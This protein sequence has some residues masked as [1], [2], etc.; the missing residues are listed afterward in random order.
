MSRTLASTG[1]LVLCVV[2]LARAQNQAAGDRCL[3]VSA[4]NIV[5]G[6]GNWYAYIEIADKPYTI[7]P[8]DRLEYDIYLPA[9]NPL[10]KG[11]V[12]ADLKRD[13]LGEPL[14]SR[15]WVRDCGIK[16]QN[17]ILLHG[18]GL[19]ELAK[20][21]W[22]QRSFDLSPLAGCTTARWT[23]VFEGDLPGRYVQLLDNIRVT[24]A[25]RTALSLYEDGKAPEIKLRQTDGYSRTVLL[26]TAPRA[27][28][29]SDAA[30]AKLLEDAKRQN[31]A[32]T[33]RDQF[34]AEIDV[35][36]DLARQL[37]DGALAAEVDE[38]AKSAAAESEKALAEGRYEELL[39][40]LHRA[41]HR[42]GHAHPQM[43]KF[44]G[45]LVGHAHIDLQWLWTWDE[46]LNQIIPQ[47]FGQAVK[48]MKEFRD[49]TFSQSSACLYLAA[50]QHHPQL[51]KEMQ[52]MVARGQWEIVGGRWCEGDT[53]MIS[54]ESHVRH[55]LYGQR[56]FQSRFGRMATVG[57]EPDTFGHCWTLPQVLR[58][59]GIDSY[60]FCRAG[61][62][63]PL[64][65]W[66]GP[67]GSRVLAFEEPATGGW[68]N[69]VVSDEKVRE[70]AKFI[71]T[72]G[73]L[74]HLMVYGVGNH[75]GGPTREYIQ[76]ALAMRQRGLWPNIRFS[77]ASEFFKRLHEQVA[78]GAVQPPAIRDELNPVFEGCYT[79]H[80]I[81]KK[82]NRDA[83]TLLETAE[84]WAALAALSDT[85][86]VTSDKGAGGQ[87]GSA[88][89]SVTLHVSPVT[90]G[91]TGS[92]SG[93]AGLSTGGQAAGG[94]PAGAS[95]GVSAGMSDTK[96]GGAVPGGPNP[97]RQGAGQ[98]PANPGGPGAGG[99][100]LGGRGS[101]FRYPRA[102]FEEMWRDVLWNHHHDTLP[103]SFIHPS[104]VFS[105]KMYESLLERGGNVLQESQ[106]RLMERIDRERLWGR[107]PHIVVFNPLAWARSEAVQAELRIPATE[108]LTVL[109]DSNGDV[110]TQVVDRGFVGDVVMMRIAFLA[111]NVP[112]GGF[113]VFSNRGTPSSTPEP[114]TPKNIDHLWPR[115]PGAQG[116]VDPPAP[117]QRAWFH[118][119]HERP[120]DMSAW[121][122]GEFGPPI[123]VEPD[124]TPHLIED[125][126]V[127]RRVRQTFLHDRSLITQD[128]IMYS[129]SPLAQYQTTVDW[130]QLGNAKDGG[131]MLKVAFD[132]G[133]KA[134]TALY[135]I[136]FGDIERNN[137]GH[138]NVALKWCA[139][140][141]T[142]KGGKTR[143]VA[144]LNDC[145]H[146]YDVKDGVIRL[147]LLRSSY[148]PDPTPDVGQ[149]YMRYAVLTMDGP[150]DKAAVVR[151][152]WEFNKP[153]QA[154]VLDEAT[155]PR[156]DAAT[157]GSEP[158]AQ[159]RAA[160]DAREPKPPPGKISMDVPPS[161]DVK[162]S[163]GAKP[164][165]AP[166]GGGAG[167][168][169]TGGDN[170][171][172]VAGA[173]RAAA[174]AMLPPVWSGLS[175]EPANIIVTALKLA[176]DND[177]LILRA[178]ECAGKPSEATFT[179]GFDVKS[180]AENDLLEREAKDA[181]PLT[182]SGRTL[183]AMFKPYEIRTIRL[184]R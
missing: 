120:H 126:T 53:N 95:E 167:D 121:Q 74:D 132:T 100:A 23:V 115:L 159:A 154:V 133:L 106:A 59:A 155:M 141:G 134:D 17:G 135:D 87:P 43:Q 88:G 128:L 14:R 103:G 111:R 93:R 165:A 107:G 112:G 174:K 58:K 89:S 21:K 15:P 27:D 56:Y 75:G 176:E 46:T 28:L 117:P 98:A 45:H 113:K 91:A 131:P 4:E 138:E 49:F 146:A 182:L 119:L 11:G 18:D 156:S 42:L 164:G 80:S 158:E 104:A 1:V 169:G 7:Q 110:P 44:T 136:P 5:T 152:A 8:G 85:W 25:G 9:L 57:W 92:L 81:I 54:P 168:A 10:L 78:S 99:P 163:Q 13:G 179:L 33:A 63:L 171:G 3:L 47:T 22:Y 178:Y 16:D 137:D 153:L 96:V 172:R 97:P 108:R 125:G 139:V 84:V 26:T 123:T 142:D 48:F 118:V 101:D 62:G 50:E 129:T 150:L 68:Y 67:D 151:A 24:N 173:A 116:T 114:V 145:K 39:E 161:T 181:P 51:F 86:Q 73:G 170:A 30:V 166:I 36:R 71:A 60:Y 41:R 109:C 40:A 52:E 38:V 29:L 79:T 147:T 35:A 20:D 55:L 140:T 2:A 82:Y 34:R 77:T 175:A 19:L 162:I 76:A 83:E 130:Q 148:E 70:L 32:R 180:A 61:K 122:V 102:A 177:D 183:T 149:H 31:E 65:W 64:F 72:T 69:D 12:D 37:K 124:G 184:R 144:V 6:S 105:Y 143:T 90:P 66:E 94:T 160:A 157:H 127:R